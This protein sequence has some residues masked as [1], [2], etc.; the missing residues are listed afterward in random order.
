MDKEVIRDVIN[1]FEEENYVD[2]K[3]VLTKEI[4][5]EKDAYLKDKLSLKPDEEWEMSKLAEYLDEARKDWSYMTKADDSMADF[6]AEIEMRM[7]DLYLRDSLIG[8]LDSIG[9]DWDKLWTKIV[10]L[11]KRVK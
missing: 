8:D 7:D 10:R 1:K 9:R 5:R 2:A 4:R 11:T 6:F 3:D